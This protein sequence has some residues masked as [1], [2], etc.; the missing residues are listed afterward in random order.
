MGS[1]NVTNNPFFTRETQRASKTR[2][3][4]RTL[5]DLRS[6]WTRGGSLRHTHTRARAHKRIRTRARTHAHTH[7]HKH[8]RT[9]PAHTHTHTHA[10]TLPPT[11]AHPRPPTN[12]NQ[13]GARTQTGRILDG[14]KVVLGRSADGG[15]ACCVRP[16]S[17]SSIDSMDA[18]QGIHAKSGSPCRGCRPHLWHASPSSNTGRTERR[19]GFRLPTIWVSSGFRLP[20]S[21]TGRTERR[22]GFPLHTPVLVRHAAGW[23]DGEA[24]RLRKCVLERGRWSQNP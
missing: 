15:Q 12:V 22:S 8:A 19:S 24:G 16:A 4:T 18:W 6:A 11:H 3:L 14:E 21:N 2:L 20:S 10:H 1:G 7:A 5:D 17:P 13:C 23:A 9:H